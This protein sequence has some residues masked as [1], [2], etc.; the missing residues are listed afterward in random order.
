MLTEYL[1]QGRADAEVRWMEIMTGARVCRFAVGEA[2][3]VALEPRL[4]PL[5]FETLFCC[6][7]GLIL[8]RT[9]GRTLRAEAGEILLLSDHSSLRGARIEGALEGLLVAVDARSARESL[10]RLCA[11]MGGL[12]LDIRQVR[13]RMGEQE[14][15]ALLRGLPWSRALFA[16]LEGLSPE[17][18]GRYCVWKTVELLYLLCTHSGLLEEEKVGVRPDSYLAHTV[19][20]MRAYME[21]HLE[22]K[23]TIPDMSRRFCISP[24][25]FKAC[26]RRLYGR[27][28]HQWLQERRMERAAG[29]L[30][31]SPMTVLQAAQCVGY[32]GVS[33]FNAAFKR[34]YGVTPGQYR[35]MSET[36]EDWLFRKDGAAESCYTSKLKEPTS[37]GEEES[38]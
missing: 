7:G 23:L 14:G 34:R 32:D 6:G 29:L 22:E 24:T 8:E 4:E 26:F 36:G 21:Q 19:C 35:K 1:R 12:E 25:A 30:R 20:R 38:L 2:D 13:R 18:Q 33:Q 37:F 31:G 27:P 3:G 11:L 17:E 16:F 28:V 5:H 9:Q 10:G 15:C